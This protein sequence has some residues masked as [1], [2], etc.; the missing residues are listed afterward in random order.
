ML[1][2]IRFKSIK[3]IT[4]TKHIRGKYATYIFI[5]HR[6][7]TRRLILSS[8]K[9]LS[10]V[11]Q[12]IFFTHIQSS[13]TVCYSNIKLDIYFVIA[14]WSKNVKINILYILNNQWMLLILLS[15]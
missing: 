11:L 14:V 1:L 2:Y 4:K 15:I 12:V 5:F 6:H 9:F 8:H 3:P 10:N 13:F 7:F